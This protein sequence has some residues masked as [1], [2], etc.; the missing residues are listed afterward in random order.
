MMKKKE[1][2]FNLEG[3]SLEDYMQSQY[4]DI[5]FELA[6]LSRIVKYLKPRIKNLKDKK[7][8]YDNIIKNSVHPELIFCEDGDFEYDNHD[9]FGDFSEDI[10]NLSDKALECIAKIEDGWR[11]QNL[12]EDYYNEKRPKVTLVTKNS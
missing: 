10:T 1:L 12:A 11:K 9:D 8:F 7:E 2:T 3:I 6:Y 5:Q 4:K